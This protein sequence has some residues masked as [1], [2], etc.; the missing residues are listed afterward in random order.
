KTQSGSHQAGRYSQGNAGAAPTQDGHERGSFCWARILARGCE[1]FV[2]DQAITK[3][4]K[5]NKTI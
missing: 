1:N 5:K 3:G 4:Y 2:N